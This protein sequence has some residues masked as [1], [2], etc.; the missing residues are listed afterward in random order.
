MYVYGV[1]NYI[2][3]CISTKSGCDISDDDMMIKMPP[4]L[5]LIYLCPCHTIYKFKMTTEP[6]IYILN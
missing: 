3:D 1:F 5:L 6:P 2:V 4:Y